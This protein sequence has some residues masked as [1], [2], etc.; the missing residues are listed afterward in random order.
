MPAELTAEIWSRVN[1]DLLAKAIGEFGYEELLAPEPVGGDRYRLALASGVRYEF[2]AS[3]GAYGAWF[4]EPESLR[5]FAGNGVRRADDALQFVHDALDDLGLPGDTAGHLVRELTAT[6]VADARLV[7]DAPTAE[8]LADASYAELEGFQTGHPWIVPNKGRMG[9]S[10]SDAERFAPEARRPLRLPWMAV[11]TGLATYKG[12]EGLTASALYDL[13]LDDATTKRF[14]EVLV[15]RGLDPDRYLWLPVHPWQWDNI[16]A[17]LFAPDIAAGRIVQLGD[18]PDEYLAQQSIRTFSN[19]TS[20]L[21]HHVK[22][23]LSILNTLVWRGLPTERTLAAPAVTAWVLGLAEADPFLAEETRP[24]L[25]G[26][27][28]SVTVRHDLLEGIPGVPYHYRELL[29]VIWR[30]SIT[31]K[32]DP[33]ERARTL[34]SLL[35]VDQKGTPLVAELVQRSGRSALDWLSALFHALL[36][37]LL[38]FL[39]RY[40][41]VFSPHGENTIV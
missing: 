8:T 23:P 14:T 20:P 15:G 18:G 32:L 1:A 10:A 13:E 11:E 36:P 26:E 34:A 7:R 27:V 31:G 16:V 24:V 39:Y 35:Y 22:L 38:H 28:A 5:R 21:R 25:L 19:V 41:V 6:L 30:Q 40:G 17:P 4:V 2:R 12:V 37:P 29:G 3:R 9:F 33:A